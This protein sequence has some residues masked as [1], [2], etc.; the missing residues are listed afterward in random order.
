MDTVIMVKVELSLKNAAAAAA[1]VKDETLSQVVRRALRDYV[2]DNAQNNLP[3]PIGR[4]R[5]VK[6]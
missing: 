6:L 3:L 1:A 2:R 4:P 5:K